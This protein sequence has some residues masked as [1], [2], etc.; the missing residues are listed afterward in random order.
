MDVFCD[1]YWW[2]VSFRLGGLN[3]QLVMLVES[4]Q[5]LVWSVSRGYAGNDD[6]WLGKSE[7]EVG[8]WSAGA[9]ERGTVRMETF[10]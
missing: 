9:W 4:C 3:Y 1:G 5:D 6:K 8:E 2:A 7:A 10:K